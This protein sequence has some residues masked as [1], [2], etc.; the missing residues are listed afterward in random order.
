MADRWLKKLELV[1]NM[2]TDNRNKR[3]LYNVDYEKYE[4]EQFRSRFRLTKDGFCE[5]LDILRPDISAHNERGRPIPADIQLL[6]T[7]FY[8]TGT[9]QLACGD[10]C[11]ISEPSASSIIMRVSESIARNTMQCK[12][13]TMQIQY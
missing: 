13:N 8:A 12:N 7:I 1:D 6:L 10:L 9:F 2:P 5:L 4:E 3:K 11:E